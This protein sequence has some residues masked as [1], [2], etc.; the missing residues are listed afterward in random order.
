MPDQDDDRR[1]FLKT[2]GKFAAVTPPT[3]TLLCYQRSSRPTRLHS[4]ARGRFTTTISTMATMAGAM[5]AAMAA[6]T[7][8]T[9]EAA[10]PTR[11]LRKETQCTP[12]AA[13]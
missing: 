2:C 10:E 1:E 12:G 8:R 7:G 4:L 9:I 11:G 5:A 6:P 3:I 13:T